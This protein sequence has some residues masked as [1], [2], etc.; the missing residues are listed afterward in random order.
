VAQRPL[1]IN[2]IPQSSWSAPRPA[3]QSA[4]VAALG[5]WGGQTSRTA[6]ASGAS[7]T[8]AAAY[9]PS[10]DAGA[11]ITNPAAL[12][13]NDPIDFPAIP[14]SPRRIV[15]QPEPIAPQPLDDYNYGFDYNNPFVAPRRLSPFQGRTPRR[16][17]V[18]DPWSLYGP[19]E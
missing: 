17:E 1:Q 11:A 16:R 19:N 3:Y 7:S 4:A 6:P 14:S 12:S 10:Y 9:S 8:A 13:L 2:T 15:P 5:G 18:Y